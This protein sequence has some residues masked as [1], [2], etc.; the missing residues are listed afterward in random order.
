MPRFLLPALLAVLLAPSVPAAEELKPIN[1]SKVNTEADEDD[2][3][4]ASAT[5]LFY[6]SNPTG[7]FEIFA[8]GRSGAFWTRG[9]AV[10]S[11]PGKADA[12]S[13]FL[14]Y[15]KADR[16]YYAGNHD[17]MAKDERGDNFDLWY[18]TRTGAAG[19][20]AIEAAVQSV[21]TRA[22][23]AFPWITPDNKLYFGRRTKDGWKLYVS[24]R[25]KGGAFGK[26][27][28]VDL[29]ADFGHP[30]LT[31]DGKTMFL[32]GALADGRTGIFRSRKDTEGKWT[33]PEEVAGLAH[34]DAK[35]GDR[36]PG[37][38][39][40]GLTLYFASDR[41]GGK[42]GLDLW[43]IRVADLPKPKK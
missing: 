42:G 17:V 16:L 15:A 24:E 28:A 5:Q 37:L 18:Q 36:S 30:T 20:F 27:M 4:P 12:R 13:P 22:D 41:P 34:P 39:R 40:D 1:L 7:K 8:A 11:L 23:E 6:A 21:C 26:P 14:E 38:T 31:P 32:Q 33:E 2:P 10:I 43:L 19:E 9:K 3:N 35:L 25:P 29:P